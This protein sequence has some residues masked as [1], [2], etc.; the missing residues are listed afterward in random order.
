[1]LFQMWGNKP[2]N[3][4]CVSADDL[5]KAFVIARQIDASI[6]SGQMIAKPKLKTDNML[7]VREW[8]DANNWTDSYIQTYGEDQAGG[9]G[10]EGW[11]AYGGT[12]DQFYVMGVI[13]HLFHTGAP[14]TPE[15][16]V[17]IKLFADEK[18]AG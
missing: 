5:D 1:M 9:F 16:F 10:R 11:G 8:L 2:K 4:I 12:P 15:L 7:T 6:D 13:W 14:L 18:E 17:T 3:A